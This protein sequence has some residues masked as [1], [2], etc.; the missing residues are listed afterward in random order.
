MVRLGADQDPLITCADFTFDGFIDGTESDGVLV[1][2]PSTADYLSGRYEPGEYEVTITGTPYKATDGR[3]DSAKFTITLLDPCDPPV[4]IE[5]P[6]L[7]DQLY[8][9]TAKQESYE[10][11]DFIVTPSY[12]PIY[13]SYVIQSLAAGDS[14]ITQPYTEGDTT[15]TIY[16]NNDDAP[17][18]PVL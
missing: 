7:D 15:F 8:L 6:G 18:N 9:L 13:Y 17:V 4:S 5:S 1:F 12:C 11:P 2:R 3:S 16:Y 14:A 10:H